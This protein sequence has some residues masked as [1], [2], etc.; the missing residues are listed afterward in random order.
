M[1]AECPL[2]QAELEIDTECIGQKINCPSCNKD[3]EVKNPNLMPCPDCFGMISK[4][5]VTCPHCGAPINGYP[6]GIANNTS[7]KTS[8]SEEKEILVCH[9]SAM[10]Y[11]WDIILGIV[12]IPVVIG[13]IILLYIWIEIHYTSYR[14]TN[15]RIIVRR[16]LIAKFQN[17]IWIKDMRGANLVQGIWQ[18]FIGVG[19]ISVGTAATAGTEICMAGIRNP[20][21]IV[22]I[23]NSL[24]N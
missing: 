8:T 19:N 9:P 23:I 15:L 2:C 6:S 14:I 10:T 24:R 3:F 13:I 21:K 7:S 20:Q 12:T 1:K 18:R 5:A 17:E 11:L 16:G 22:D 4:R